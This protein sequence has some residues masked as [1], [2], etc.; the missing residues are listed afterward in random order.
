[1]IVNNPELS[2]INIWDMQYV[3]N[4]SMFNL[5]QKVSKNKTKFMKV[6]TITSNNSTT[7]AKIDMNQLKEYFPIESV[8][9]GVINI[10]SNLFDIKMT[11][12]KVENM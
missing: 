2:K 7:N 8:I 5:A 1:M 12:S 10:Y 11:E 9:K 4:Y 6:S 3:S